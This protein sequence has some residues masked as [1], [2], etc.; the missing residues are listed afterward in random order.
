VAEEGK[1]ESVWETEESRNRRWRVYVRVNGSS[2]VDGHAAVGRHTAGSRQGC[3]NAE[4]CRGEGRDE[5]LDLHVVSEWSGVV[6]SCW[7]VR[8]D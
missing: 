8:S 3:S 7:R 2:V 1:E 6:L 5:L 4:R